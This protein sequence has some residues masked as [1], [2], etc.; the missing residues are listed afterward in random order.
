MPHPTLRRQWFSA[1]AAAI[2]VALFT[3]RSA[4]QIPVF[5]GGHFTSML[6]QLRET[7]NLLTQ[8]ESGASQLEQAARALPGSTRSFDDIL[9]G[10]RRLTGDLNAISYDMN[11]VTQQFH[12]VYP[13]EAAVQKTTPAERATLAQGWDQ[14]TQLAA[15]AAARSQTTLSTIDTNTNSARDILSRS[16]DQSSAVAQLQALVQMI[17]VINS[18]L[19]NLAT[20]LDATGRVNASLAGT[21][22]SSREV[23]EERRRRQ[24]SNYDAQRSSPGIDAQFLQVP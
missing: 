6:E 8:L 3:R 17:Q 9:L 23:A 1:A 22:A 5:D 16:S 24:L 15:L 21:Q 12:R 20:T 18:D 2:G 7:A 4:A 13:D 19:G 10:A 14:Q 11:T